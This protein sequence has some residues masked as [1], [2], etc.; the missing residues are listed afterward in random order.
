M[1]QQLG[2]LLFVKASLLLVSCL[3]L[4]KAN[5]PDGFYNHSGCLYAYVDFEKST[6]MFRVPDGNEAQNG[7]LRGLNWTGQEHACPTAGKAGKLV[8][9]FEINDN[10]M[11]GITMM[12][13]I[14]TVPHLGYWEVDKA[15]MTIRPQSNV[16][17]YNNHKEADL[18]VNDIYADQSHSYSCSELVLENHVMLKDKSK[19]HQDVPHFK[20]TLHRF[21]VQPFPELE[22]AVFAP[23]YDCA[24]WLTLPLI[25]GLI[26]VLFIVFTVLIGVSLLMDQGNQTSDLRFSKQGGMLMNQAQLDATKG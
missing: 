6:Y 12:L 8:M 19:T 17:I 5:Y 23:S 10:N 1:K 26:L 3:R 22:K 20:I 7:T 11:V 24:V 25:M 14:K 4:V 21:Q 2:L 18:K 9:N 13:Q 16:Q 15:H